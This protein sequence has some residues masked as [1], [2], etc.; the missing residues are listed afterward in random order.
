MK[1]ILILDNY[2]SFTYNLVQLVE[3][4]S[5]TR[6]DVARND[7]IAVEQIAEYEKLILS[8]GPGVPRENGILLDC[9]KAYLTEKPILGVCLGHQAI[10]EALGGSLINMPDV[11]HGISSKINIT[12][13]KDPLLS[14]LHENPEVGHYHSWIVDTLSL[15]NELEVLATDQDGQI[16][17]IKH[18]LH[19]VW[20]VQFHPESVLSPNGSSIIKNFLDLKH[21]K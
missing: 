20:G 21:I 7:Q 5:G 18:K 1:P 10:A 6:P 17:A 2:D 19:P 16:M 13:E 8:P 15:P 4:I 3:E 14:G 9:I 11:L 12:A